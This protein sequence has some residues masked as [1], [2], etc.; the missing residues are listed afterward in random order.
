MFPLN[1][2]KLKQ[3][4]NRTATATKPPKMTNRARLAKREKRSAQATRRIVVMV[5]PLSV[6]ST[7]SC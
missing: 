1:W 3:A 7:R 5:M 2:L 6:R 4:E